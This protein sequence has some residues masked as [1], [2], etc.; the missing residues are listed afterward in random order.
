MT[1]VTDELQNGVKMASVPAMNF[2]PTLGLL[3]STLTLLIAAISF[4]DAQSPMPPIPSRPVQQPMPPIPSVG[5]PLLT[6]RLPEETV[7]ATRAGIC[8]L[9]RSAGFAGYAMFLFFTKR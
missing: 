7:C 2:A 1:T 6:P 3:F 5:Q 8:S 9:K 4:A